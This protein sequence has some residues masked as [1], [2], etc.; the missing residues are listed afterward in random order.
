MDLNPESSAYWVFGLATAYS[1]PLNLIFLTFKMEVM[2]EAKDLAH[3]RNS[4]N[5]TSFL[6]KLRHIEE[7]S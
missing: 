6:L 5:A 7:S 4:V 1:V 2:T 3:I